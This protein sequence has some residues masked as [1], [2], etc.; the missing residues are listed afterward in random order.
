[1]VYIPDRTANDWNEPGSVWRL[2]LNMGTGERPPDRI[3]RFDTPF[4][5]ELRAL[6]PYID[7]YSVAYL[8]RF[9]D[10]STPAP[11]STARPASQTA[12]ATEVLF[13]A[14]GA[15]G[16]MRF[17]WRLDAGPEPPSV[18]DPGAGE[19]PATIK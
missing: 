2:A 5:A 12:T 7:E 4:S 19:Q 15:P 17:Y 6:Y 10:P 9:P 3:Q 16:Q 8:V 11:G 13:I 1:V 18:G 14:A